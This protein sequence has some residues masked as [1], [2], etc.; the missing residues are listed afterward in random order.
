M[1]FFFF[2][3]GGGGGGGVSNYRQVANQKL[4]QTGREDG[5]TGGWGVLGGFWGKGGDA[6]GVGAV[7]P[8]AKEL[9]AFDPVL[10]EEASPAVGGVWVGAEFGEVTEL[11][12]GPAFGSSPSLNAFEGP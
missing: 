2:F 8:A 5:E 10:A 7:I 4:A 9:E 12:P 6:G 1:D 11:D 3:F